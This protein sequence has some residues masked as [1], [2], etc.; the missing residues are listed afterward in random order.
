MGGNRKKPFSVKQKKAQMQAKRAKKREQAEAEADDWDFNKQNLSFALPAEELEAL[1]ITSDKR[2]T[3]ATTAATT[4]ATASGSSNATEPAD[5]TGE[6]VRNKLTSRFDKL[7][8]QQVEINKRISMRPLQ[9]LSAEEG[10][11]MSFEDAY[12]ADV[13]IPVRPLWSYRQSR[14]QLEK[15]EEEY[16]AQWLKEIKELQDMDS[17]SLYEKNLEVWRQLWRVVEIS[18]ILLLVVDIRHPVL[19]FP[20]SLYRYISETTGKPIVVVFNKTDLVAANTVRAWKHYFKQQFPALVLTSFCCYR[21]K[22]LANDTNLCDLKMRKKKPR[23]RVYDSSL[24]GDL[25][26]AC[27]S[28]CDKQKRSLVDWDALVARYR[29]SESDNE[30]GEG[31]EEV[32]EDDS[33]GSSDEDG[34]NKEAERGDAEA[35]RKETADG[36]VETVSSKYVTLGLVGHP[37]VGKSTVIN[38]IMGRTVVS[39]S[40]TPGHTKHFQTIH[41]TPTLRLCDCP[42]LVFP[43]VVERPLQIL[44]GLYNIA[45]VQEPFTCVKYLAERVPVEKVLNLQN[46]ESV[47]TANGEWSAWAICEAFAIDRGFYTSKAARPDVYRAALH[48][49]RWE[50]DG[51]V[52]LSFK[53]PNFH[54]DFAYLREDEQSLLVAED[55]RDERGNSSENGGETTSSASGDEDSDNDK[56]I[57]QQSAFAILGDM[58]C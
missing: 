49:L 46:P 17:V 53:P 18:D 54:T 35:A 58:D 25:F 44:A 36:H 11:T 21:D 57:G 56:P 20:P 9:R 3:A 24:V 26:E 33:D 19:H 8:R 23:K 10:L 5:K 48:I 40:R 38:S 45:Q 15:R 16:F 2:Q 30:D 43:C 14:E 6:E 42:G 41:V 27:Q 7:S 39:T 50:L 28:V 31:E 51:R 29:S 1:N 55:R 4:G 34:G 22:V 52:L 13:D 12:S 37:N 47:S 32:D